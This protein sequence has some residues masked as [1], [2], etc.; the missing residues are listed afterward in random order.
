MKRVAAAAAVLAAL[1]VGTSLASASPTHEG[2]ASATTLTVWV[3]WSARELS[4]FKKVVQ[5]Y[6]AKNKDVEAKVV[7][8]STTT[9]SSRRYVRATAPTS[10]ARSR[11]PTSGS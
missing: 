1:A 6:D 4:E 5:E 7:G 2:K 3:G 8:A 11:P 10:S 9:R